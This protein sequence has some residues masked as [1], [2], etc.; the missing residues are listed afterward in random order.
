MADVDVQTVQYTTTKVKK[1]KKTTSGKR[2]ESQDQSEVTISEVHDKE[3]VLV[4]GKGYV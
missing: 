1:T 4:N 2:R 3:N